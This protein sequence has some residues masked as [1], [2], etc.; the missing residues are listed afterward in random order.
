MPIQRFV[1][2]TVRLLDMA[3]AKACLS[4]YVD[5]RMAVWLPIVSLNASVV[6]GFIAVDG[7]TLLWRYRWSFTQTAADGDFR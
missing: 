1:E 4:L 2:P 3:G 5:G 7:I 6:A